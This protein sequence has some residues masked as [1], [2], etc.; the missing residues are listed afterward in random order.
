MSLE[1]ILFKIDNNPKCKLIRNNKERELPSYLP[2]D[3]LLFYQQYD[4]IDFFNKESYSIQIVPFNELK[5]TNKVLFSPND[6]IWE[7]LEHDI[8]MDWYLIAK[9]EQLAQYI[10]ID[11]SLKTKG[12]CYDSFLETHANPNESSIISKSFIELLDR[13]YN[14]KGRD[15]YWLESNFQAYGDAYFVKSE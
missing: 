6:V 1:E 15:W 10:S 5:Q 3:L 2:T 7:E 13:I 4:G 8:S 9:S 14:A 11:F 12:F